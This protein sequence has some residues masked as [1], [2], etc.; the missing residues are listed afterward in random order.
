MV[1]LTDDDED[2]K[3][4]E[5]RTEKFKLSAWKLKP[6]KKQGEQQGG[7]DEPATAV[8]SESSDDLNPNPE[9]EARPK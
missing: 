6:L 4:I 9:S 2:P 3:N 5:V 8:E 7:A 1:T